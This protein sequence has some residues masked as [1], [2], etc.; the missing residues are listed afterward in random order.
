MDDRT[1]SENDL[2]RIRPTDLL[3]TLLFKGINSSQSVW[4]AI[5]E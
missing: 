1:E 2:D 3:R 4:M 5:V